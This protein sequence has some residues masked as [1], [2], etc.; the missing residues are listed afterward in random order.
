MNY[1]DFIIIIPLLWAAYKGFKKGLIIEIASLVALLLGIWGAIRFSGYTS[2]LLKDF[3]SNASYLPL[4][5]FGIT[6]L[7][8]VVG[9]HFVAKLIDRF[10]KAVALNLVNRLAGAAFGVI[11]VAFI[12]SIV[13]L[14]I[15][16][17]D[18]KS[19]FISADFINNSLLYKPVAGLAPM[20]F[21][22]LKTIDISVPEVFEDKE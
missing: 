17:I 16:R 22:S 20:I 11:K 7:I 18:K 3:F 12:V 10:V 13:L 4:V 14:L 8:I 6:F 5:A 15:N 21:P 1:F 19:D 9:V 2:V